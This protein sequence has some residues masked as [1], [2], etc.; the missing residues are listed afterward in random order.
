MSGKKITYY[1]LIAFVIGAAILGYVQY[2]SSRNIDALIGGNEAL[3]DEFAISGE[4]KTLEKDI[5]AIE[6]KTRGYI[7][8]GNSGHNEGL[9]GKIVEARA[10]IK[11][12]YKAI[13]DDLS[14]GHLVQLD[15]LVNRKL[16]WNEK[17]Q[18]TYATEGKEAA[19]KL[20]ATQKGRYLTDSISNTIATLDAARRQYM[21]DAISTLDDNGLKAKSHNIIL[22]ICLMIGAAIFFWYTIN[23]A[24][25]Q[26][27]LIRELNISERKVKESAL[28]K[29]RF[30]ANMSHEIRTPLNA[31]LGFINLLQKKPL[32]KESAEYVDTIRKSGENLLN[33]V[34]DILDLSKIEAHMMHVE[35]APFSIRGLVHSIQNM[36]TSKSN[37]KSIKMIAEIDTSLPD[38]LEG[39]ATKLTQVLVNLIG[40]AI[41][42]THAGTITIKFTNEG[43]KDGYVNTGI[44]ISDTG[45]GIEEDKLAHIFERFRQAEDSVNRHYGGTGL[46]LTIVNELIALQKGKITVESTPGKGTTFIVSI[47]YKISEPAAN[48]MEENTKNASLADFSA[49]KILVVEDNEINQKLIRHL[50]KNWKLDY[51]MASNG[52]EAV[53]A[54]QHNRYN[55][56]LMDIQMPEMDGYTASQHIREKLNL[57][58]P[59][60]AMTAHAFAGEREKCLSYGMNDYISKPIKEDKLHDLIAKFATLSFPEATAVVNPN[61]TPANSDFQYI[62]LDYLKEI[63]GGDTEYEK[64]ILTVFLEQLPKETDALEAAWKTKDM[65][66]VKNIAHQLKTTVSIVGLNERLQP[67]LDATEYQELSDDEL[68]RNIAEIVRVCRSAQKES[69]AFYRQ[70]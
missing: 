8:T 56:I 48:G 35:T 12:L 10:K 54:L 43:I 29:E 69:E 22:I 58:T 64:T 70:L 40:N 9:N 55:M 60:I 36:F 62:S 7:S 33:I 57:D 42:F 46:G 30:L 63:S 6:S 18:K 23:S 41:K 45:I 52:L 66:T 59:I 44:Y 47:P 28:I 27:R 2:D 53:E 31:I 21:K 34:N 19:E 49:L 17:L 20:I 26:S 50:F 25:K 67:T 3:L 16:Q 32:D 37:E 14:R 68:E 51:D 13:D 11:A 15:T 65:Q 4:L 1:T 24:I 38:L 39:D 5:F 61:E